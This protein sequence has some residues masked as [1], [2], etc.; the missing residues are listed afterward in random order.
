MWPL[1]NDIIYFNRMVCRASIAGTA[2]TG[3]LTD[4]ETGKKFRAMWSA[5][6]LVLQRYTEQLDRDA[7]YKADIHE[8]LITRAKSNPYII[9]GRLG[10]SRQK[11][12]AA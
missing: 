11:L 3:Y 12:V 7:A 4:L 8:T 5:R 9:G 6:T 2:L 1:D 10:R